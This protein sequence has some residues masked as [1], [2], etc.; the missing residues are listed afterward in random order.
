M[1]ASLVAARLGFEPRLARAGTGPKKLLTI[2]VPGGWMPSMF[3]VPLSKQGVSTLMLSKPGDIPIVANKAPGGFTPAM[4]RALADGSDIDPGPNAPSQ[5]IRIPQMWDAASLKAGKPDSEGANPLSEQMGLPTRPHGWAWVNYK[6]WEQCVVVHG[7]DQQTAA[8]ESGIISMMS[9]AAGPNYRSP[10]LHS[11]VANRFFGATKDQRALPCISIGSAPAPNPY[12]LPSVAAPTIVGTIDSVTDLL[13]DHSDYQWKGL[14]ERSMRDA[15]DYAGQAAGQLPLTDLEAYAL[16]AARARRGTTTDATDVV[17][18]KLYDGLG[19]VSKLVSR[20][21]VTLLEKTKGVEYLAQN[22][23][24][25][26]PASQQGPFVVPQFGYDVADEWNAPFDLALRF[27]KSN[28]SSSVA[29][30]CPGPESFYFDTHGAAPGAHFVKLWPTMEVIGRLLGEMKNSPGSGGGSLLDET[31]VVI[32]SE[33]ARTWPNAGDHWPST[34]VVFAGGG[35][36]DNRMIGS[37]DEVNFGAGQ[38][39]TGIPVDL[40]DESGNKVSRPPTSADI[41]FT[42]LRALDIDSKEFFIP[43]GPGEIVGVRKS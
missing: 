9:G 38:S 15:V 24:Y 23:P 43:G 25:W 34:S 6:L 16:D 12:N 35:I 33:F 3:F 11:V 5:P 39:P 36:A 42:A 8:H 32:W 14:R 30:S 18:Q 29:L 26:A 17:L 2:Y 37:Y 22:R 7:V 27:L 20:D 19:D 31:L 28:L 40:L 4:V 21:V 10:A 41:V 1:G 13:S